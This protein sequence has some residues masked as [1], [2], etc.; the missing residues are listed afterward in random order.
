MKD[1]AIGSLGQIGLPEGLLAID[2]IIEAI[3]DEDIS[4]KSKAIWAIGRLARGCNTKVNHFY[5]LFDRF[6]IV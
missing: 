5:K 2:N 3:K 6:V 4:V 1:A